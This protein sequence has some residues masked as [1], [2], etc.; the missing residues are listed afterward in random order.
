MRKLV[1]PCR[2]YSQSQQAY[3][4]RPP[5]LVSTQARSR[6]A[7]L[8]VPR[9]AARSLLVLLLCLE[10]FAHNHG[11][12]RGVGALLRRDELGRALRVGAVRVCGREGEAKVV[13]TGSSSRQ[14]I[15]RKRARGGERRERGRGTHP[16]SAARATGSVEHA[17]PARRRPCASRASRTTMRGGA[18]T[19]ACAGP[20]SGWKRERGGARRNRRSVRGAGKGSGEGRVGQ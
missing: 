8:D 10:R 17:R 18:P 11:A 16:P 7:H 5:R 6:L 9:C 19:R 20:A 3:S 15:E 12:A 1:G 13:S 14:N 2:L 4:A